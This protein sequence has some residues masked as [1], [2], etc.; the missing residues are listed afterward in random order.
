MKRLLWFALLFVCTANSALDV[1]AQAPLVF[2]PRTVDLAFV[3]GNE[4]CPS[5]AITKWAIAS[6]G[7]PEGTGFLAVK[8]NA[9]KTQ[10][11]TLADQTVVTVTPD[12]K[13]FAGHNA[14][15]NPPTMTDTASPS[16]ADQLSIVDRANLLYA[17]LAIRKT[18]ASN[19]GR[20][21]PSGIFASKVKS[22]NSGGEVDE[23]FELLG[24]KIIDDADF[25]ASIP[26]VFG[27]AVHV[28]FVMD[29]K[30]NGVYARSLYDEHGTLAA[31]SEYDYS[32]GRHG[33][34]WRYALASKPGSD[35]QN[36]I[37]RQCERS[38]SVWAACSDFPI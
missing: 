17:V 29:E 19:D 7:L 8:T 37:V 16:S 18:R 9:D 38:P 22:L 20:T 1:K 23:L 21:L 6:Y 36:T 2:T 10:S 31:I 30:N 11:M 24:F 13:V 15:F 12:Q 25:P 28:V 14:H 26:N 27:S 32:K 33:H 35:V 34:L 5:V 4:N 3:Q